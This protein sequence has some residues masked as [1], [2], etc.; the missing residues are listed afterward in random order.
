MKI[1]LYSPA[2]A[3][4]VDQQSQAILFKQ[5]GHEVMLLTWMPEGILHE[6]FHAIGVAAYSTQV[7]GRSIFFF[8][9]QI[10]FFIR[11]CRKEKIDI[12]FCNGQGCGVVAGIAKY[13]IRTK[14]IYVRH[15]SVIYSDTN[16]AKDKWLNRLANWLSPHI[17]A[18]SDMVKTQLLKEHVPANRIQRINLCYDPREYKND[19]AGK[20]EE[21]QQLYKADLLVLYIA[22]LVE[23][24]RHVLAFEAV[25]LLNTEG[26]DC[27]LVCIGEG[28]YKH[29]LEQWIATNA[30]EEKIILAGWVSNV[31]DHIMASDIVLLLSA[32]EASS[33][34]VKEAAFCNKTVIVCRHVGDFDETII[35]GYNGFLVDPKDPVEE[36]A[37]ILK[38]IIVDRSVLPK[39]S[40]NL[41][42]TVE[43]NFS[44]DAVRGDYEELFRG[45]HQTNAAVHKKR[46]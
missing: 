9:K 1:L 22:R 32:S 7:K 10:Q 33:H 26:I 34:I 39:L 3:R 6:N 27:K 15:N 41:L 37:E 43:E 20:S 35:P 16:S 40:A 13:F 19:V 23:M 42:K 2:N 31:F 14:T 29:I 17:M 4:A 25:Q 28:E 18:I 38:R 8:I 30:M 46:F 36:T 11:F 12:A 44:M 24:K 45:I 21:I 5:M